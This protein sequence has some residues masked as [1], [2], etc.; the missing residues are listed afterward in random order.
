MSGAPAASL[1]FNVGSD[2]TEPD[3]YSAIYSAPVPRPILNS[4]LLWALRAFTPK[5]RAGI[6]AGADKGQNFFCPLGLCVD[7]P[8]AGG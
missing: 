4:S 6:G 5:A 8:W 3:P 2:R 7:K 1:M